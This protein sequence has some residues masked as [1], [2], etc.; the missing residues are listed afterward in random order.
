MSEAGDAAP[1]S[2]RQGCSFLSYQN[3]R[4]RV[5]LMDFKTSRANNMQYINK[6]EGMLGEYTVP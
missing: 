4:F 5:P 6:A 3:L 2:Y 1:Q